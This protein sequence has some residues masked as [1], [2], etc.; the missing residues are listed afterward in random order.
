M[1]K[2]NAAT[3]P[4][5]L[6]TDVK[7]SATKADFPIIGIGASAGGLEAIEQFLSQA[8]ADCG[9]AFVVVQHLDP[10]H[11]GIMCEL[12]QRVTPLKVLQISDRMMV[13]P[14]HVYVIP[15]AYDL[16]L[17]NGTLLLFPRV[18][19]HGLHLPIDYFL[20]SLA[21]DKQTQSIAVILSG[22]GSDGTLGLRAIKEKFGAVFVQRPD[23]AKFASMPKSAIDTGLVDAVAP[24]DVL[25]DNVVNYL[26]HMPIQVENTE[27]DHHDIKKVI[28]LLRSHTGH[29]FSRYKKSTIYRRIERRMALHK[30]TSIAD[31]AQY[32]RSN[33]QENELLF[34]E[35]LIGVTHFFRDS[36]VWLQLQDEVIPALL[37][38]HP[39][40]GTLRA[41][42]PA[43]S[44]GEEAYTLAIV[45]QEA[46]KQGS[47][48]QHFELQIFATDLDNDAVKKARAGI[49][50]ASIADDIAQTRL[51]HY[52]VANKA[53]YRIG[54][55]IREMVIFA[56][57]NL[58]TDPP[59]TKLDLISC[60]NLFIY[61]EAD[62]Q[63]KLIPLFHYSLNPGG[64]LVLGTSE[65]IGKD[66]VLFS[67]VHEKLRIYQRCETI[68]PINLMS[69]PSR[70]S[71][72][73]SPEQMF[74]KLVPAKTQG[75]DDL[76]LED[77]TQSLL[78]EHFV[79]AALLTTE[80]A[81]IVY[82]N[83]K[84]G[85]YLE[86]AAGKVNH[87]LFA[88]AREGLTA[89]IS[90]VFNRAVRQK[91]KAELRNISVGTNGNT[92]QVDV[93]VQPLL[94]PASLCGM[95]LVL[96]S[97]SSMQT[98]ALSTHSSADGV[99]SATDTDEIVALNQVLQQARDDLRITTNEMQFAQENLK[100]TNEEL[101]STNEE[102][103]STNEE[104]TTSKEEMQSMNEE[105]QTVNHELNT[106][107][108][109][110]SEASDDMKNLLNSTNIATLFLDSD[111]KVRRY[112][113][114]TRSI[115]KLIASDVGRPITDLVSSLI[116][117]A[118]A[119]D[120]CEVLRSLIF[121]QTEVQTHDGRWYIV[122]IMPYRTQ[123]NL[124]DG[125]VITFSD[126]TENRMASIAMTQSESRF[127]LLFE[128]SSHAVA[129][130]RIILNND[131]AVDFNYLE[132]NN[133]YVGITE[134]HDVIGKN[135]SE[136]I[137]NILQS[138]SDFMAAC[139]RVAMSGKPEKI[140]YYVKE[141][142]QW[143]EC[144]M[145]SQQQ[146]LFVC[147]TENITDKK[148]NLKTLNNVREILKRGNNSSEA[149]LRNLLVDVQNN[150][151][152]LCKM[153]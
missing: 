120:A 90:E 42:V 18:E 89:P 28:A 86:P 83:G 108:N 78:Q 56:Q 75:V 102:L 111:L 99:D 100:S 96:F 4:T 17:L 121:Q 24:A 11:K 103:Q 132:V 128:N 23:T 66:D 49:Y 10:H 143:F 29:D 35:L 43:C 21:A 79:P 118:L 151:E 130:K 14:N 81:D 68:E 65:T 30:L 138:N 45:F 153:E 15:P 112:T 47:Y 27:Q 115:F 91:K 124:I 110:L 129:Y 122:R 133:A 145:Y 37:A 136:V 105:L 5:P 104:L 142:K 106:K 50:P 64:V 80:Q 146:G 141:T 109:E 87:N 9:M 73:Y 7:T 148:H 144:S 12:L 88:M 1:K 51:D 149:E 8:K 53:G 147:V 84:T 127:R 107:V 61:L 55:E 116:Y 48:P 52:F 57:Q 131:K 126:N 31:Y 85:N 97:E 74:E 33:A 3:A 2:P 20:K 137:P 72:G 62:L 135:G 94:Q 58:V 40:G 19:P 114:E 22:M 36:Q 63:Q 25:M 101:Q 95:V 98:S 41:W 26:N 69:F 152:K 38:K 67:A 93:S 13:K 60:R 32:L 92:V 46:L 119:D 150:L 139:G 39:E 134:L 77:L 117:P 16:T 123:E 140:E 70:T 125:V 71:G 54:K 34:N 6:T 44:S 82:I 113:T 76:N 59:F